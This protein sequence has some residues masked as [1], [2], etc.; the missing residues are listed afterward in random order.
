MG[1]AIGGL[2]WGTQEA[3]PGHWSAGPDTALPGCY[4]DCEKVDVSVNFRSA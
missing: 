4:S 1:A 3:R 2:T